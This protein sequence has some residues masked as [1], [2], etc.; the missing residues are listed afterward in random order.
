M[1]MARI[2]G[3]FFLCLTVL[4]A[5]V[6]GSAGKAAAADPAKIAYVDLRVTL[7]ESD[8]GKKA[9]AE[10]ESLIKTKQA[11][12]DEKGKAAE[13]LKTDLEKQGSVLSAEARKAKEEEVERVIRD[14]QRLVQDA[15]AEIKKKEDQHT[16]AIIKE[17]REVIDAIGREE[18]YAI[19]FENFEGMILYA[20]K[21]LDITDKVLKRFNE[22]KAKQKGNGK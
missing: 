13:K 15:Q 16:S 7:N 11:A 10:L 1:Q 21:D 4:A 12:I 18:G 9:K 8:A 20:R 2:T 19:I 6:L 3:T 5:A 17:I 22:T 14:Y